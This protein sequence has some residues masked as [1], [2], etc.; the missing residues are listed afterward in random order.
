MIVAEKLKSNILVNKNE[1]LSK[2]KLAKDFFG[3]S[4]HHL[5]GLLNI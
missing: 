1:L 2:I 3:I 4:K 5:E